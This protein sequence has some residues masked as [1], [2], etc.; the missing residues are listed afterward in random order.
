MTTTLRLDR[1]IF[2]VQSILAGAALVGSRRTPS[3]PLRR[4][5]PAS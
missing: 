1:R 2:L 4:Q 3:H 5:K